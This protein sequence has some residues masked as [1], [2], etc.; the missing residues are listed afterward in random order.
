MDKDTLRFVIVDQRK[1]VEERFKNKNIIVRDS[2]RDVRLKSPTALVILGVRRCGKSTLSEQLVLGLKFG[3]INFDDERLLGATKDDLNVVLQIFYELYGSDLDSIILDEIQIVSGWEPFVSRLR[4]TKKVIIT[5][6][7]SKLLSGELSTR[8]TGRH[9]DL[10]LFPFSFHEF[11]AYKKWD[12]PKAFSTADRAEVVKLLGEYIRSGGF[13]EQFT[14]GRQIIRSIYNDIIT[15]DVV[16]RHKIKHIDDLRQVARFLVSNSSKEFTYSSLRSITKVKNLI[17]LSNWVRY[18]EEAYLLFNVERFSYKLKQTIIAPKKIYCV[19]SGIMEGISSEP[20]ENKGRFMEN[21]VAVELIKK[22]KN[23]DEFEVFYWKDY[24]GREVDFVIKK[25]RKISQLIQVT[26]ASSREAVEVRELDSLI[27]ASKE[28]KCNNLLILTW[29]YEGS[30]RV[31][32]KKVIFMPLW[33][34]VLNA[35]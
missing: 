30:A 31:E 35:V 15:K 26:Y 29:D 12:I 2:G 22:S 7:S 25:R 1:S 33:R 11:L 17:T 32:G 24:R 9:V 21:V 34:W 19:D 8:L 4:D 5:G 13:P 23:D 6:S 16:I 27:L 14:L 10:L 20:T 3:Y 18:L 28:L